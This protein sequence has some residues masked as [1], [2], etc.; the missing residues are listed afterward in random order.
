ML[1]D[2]GLGAAAIGVFTLAAFN[3][4]KVNEPPR[5]AEQTTVIDHIGSNTQ[6][7]V[8]DHVGGNTQIDVQYEESLHAIT[9]NEH[10]AINQLPANEALSVDV[11]DKQGN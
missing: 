7:E 4:D 2:I 11:I 1:K 9:P 5:P 10:S 6:P 3:S 8:F